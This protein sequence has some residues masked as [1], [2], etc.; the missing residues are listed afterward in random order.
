MVYRT[1][2]IAQLVAGADPHV[3][4]DAYRVDRHQL[5]ALSF[6]QFARRSSYDTPIGVTIP[7]VDTG[8]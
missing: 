3:L 8:C 6:S 5:F 7:R 4:I 2:P 1:T